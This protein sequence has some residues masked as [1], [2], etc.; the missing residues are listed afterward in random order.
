MALVRV[1][2]EKAV[3]RTFSVLR[4]IA[5]F[6][7]LL[8]VWQLS[9]RLGLLNPIVLPAP[10]KVAAALWQL[11]ASG[12]L[13]A[14]AAASLQRVLLGFFISVALA[15]PLG[16]LLGTNRA[17]RHGLGP[18]LALLRPIPPIAWVPLA[19][20]W[21]GLGN[22][23]SY[24]VTMIASFFP[25]LLNTMAGVENVDPRHLNVAR[26]LG[27]SRRMIFLE[28]VLPSAAPFILSGMRVGL[29]VSW[30]SVVAAEM[31]SANRGLGY[32]I[33]S[34]QEMVQ[35]EMVIGGMFTIGLIGIILDQLLVTLNRRWVRWQ[36]PQKTI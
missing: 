22:G 8:T 28:V 30:M 4:R 18:V 11:A 7:L 25:L 5:L 34:K 35:M 27:A 32:F 24:F 3:N 2:R 6:V 12:E 10:S 14:H 16:L 15:I 36:A 29:T 1:L 20:L 21:F 33:E 23:P 31:V 17:L 9:S 26:S 19:I 13:L